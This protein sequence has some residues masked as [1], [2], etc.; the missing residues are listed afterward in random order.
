MEPPR[1]PLLI[2]DGDCGFCRAW[3][4]RWKRA[5]GER[6]EY[7]PYQ[8]VASRFPEIPVEQFKQAVQLIEPDGRW[9]QGAEAVFR[10][11][12]YAPGGG[13]LLWLY[14]KVPGFAGASEWCYRIVARHRTAFSRVTSWVW[15]AHVVPPG[16]TLTAWIFLRLLG[17]IYAIAF[18]SLW[19]QIMGLVGSRGVLPAGTFLEAVRQGYGP[20]RYWLAPT[21]CWLNAGDGFL[22][23]L[24]AVGTLLSILLAVGIAPVP[25]LI[26]LWAIYLSLATVC[27]DFLWF[28]W[29]GLLLET[30][31]LAIFLAPWR[32]WSRPNGA[33][34]PPRA[35]W[36]LLRWLLFRVTFSSA[37]VKLMS[38]DATW[39]GL[40]ALNYHYE[41]QPLPPWTAWYA[42]HLPPGF[43]KASVIA[44]F[45]IE[46]LVPLFVFAPRR[47]RFAAAGAMAGLQVLIVLTGN[48]GFFN[49]LTLALC[50]LVLD[51]GVWPRRWRE[52]LARGSP[53]VPRGRWPRWVIRSAAAVLFLLS[54]VPMFGALRW[55]AAWLGPV[56]ALYQVAEPF[57][58][59]NPYGLFAVMTTRRDEIV[60]EGSTDGATWQPY[61]FRYKPGE[62]TQRPRFV[63]PHMPRLDWQMWFAALSDFRRAPWFLHFCER[64]LQGSNPVL[65]LMERNP[66]PDAPPR[67]IRAVVYQYHF[68]DAPTRRATGAWWRREVRGLYCP[69]L[70][71]VDGKLAAVGD[72]TMR[73]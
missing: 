72:G 3:I 45:V 70:T 43:Q 12:A 17:V 15:G 14:R 31:F 55:R 6:V 61:E 42:H 57:R 9:S 65:A 16:E 50:L 2:W 67:F 5:T 20:V 32:W 25:S 28:Q 26:G 39:R 51:D 24:C 40:T 36:W 68:T 44:M 13:W 62:L 4:A 7:A 58:T 41:T 49:L 21:L 8:E 27:R 54:L 59:V 47:I 34:G 23:L 19:A 33:D 71:L 60:V 10:S 73:R 37:V 69:V 22:H 63:T 11:L 66:F 18:V 53:I 35:P 30:G 52:R 38:G 56:P 1:T 48:Y 64:L 46:G 29:D